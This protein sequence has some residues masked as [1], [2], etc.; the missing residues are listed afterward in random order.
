M[1][2]VSKEN[3]AAWLYYHPLL[4]RYARRIVNDQE[5]AAVLVKK[6][7]ADQFVLDGLQETERL[8][9][10]LK[11]DTLHSCCC[12]TQVQIFD[13]SPVKLPLR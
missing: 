9:Q 5:T 7:L 11:T 2:M 1:Q 13:R 4:V 12:Y 3:T 10:L 8:R 6:V